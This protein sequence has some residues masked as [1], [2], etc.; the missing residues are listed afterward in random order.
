MDVARLFLGRIGV[1]DDV[2]YEPLIKVLVMLATN[3]GL[4]LYLQF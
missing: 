1:H 3:H 2:Q 4:H